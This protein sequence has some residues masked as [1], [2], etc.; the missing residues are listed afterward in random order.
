MNNGQ[1]GKSYVT[2]FLTESRYYKVTIVAMTVGSCLEMIFI[3]DINTQL[4]V[5]EINFLTGCFLKIDY[6]RFCKICAHLLR[7][8]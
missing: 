4:D 3:T 2:S 1:Q 7:K 6:E 5:Q 8:L